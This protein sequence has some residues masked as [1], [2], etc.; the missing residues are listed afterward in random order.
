MRTLTLALLLAAGLSAADLD[1]NTLTVTA[2]RPLTVQPDQAQILVELTTARDAGLDDV[3][4]KLQG[5]GIA[6]A[7]LTDVFGSGAA[8]SQWNFVLPVAFSALKTTLATFTQLQRSLGASLVFSVAG[9]QVSAAAQTTQACPLPALV[10]DA[11][12]QAD[13]MASAAG[14]RTGPIVSVSDQPPAPVV[15]NV[16]EP[17]LIAGDFSVAV[18]LV[19][20]IPYVAPVAPSSCSLTVQ[21]KLL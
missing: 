3:L 4:G 21:F 11:R 14:M 1:N 20:G 9:T 18:G 15:P 17:V 12:R 7:N 19:S 8:G 2:S 13:A 16:T 10:S 6:A 5:T